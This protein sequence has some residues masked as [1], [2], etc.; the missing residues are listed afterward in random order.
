MDKS[1]PNYHD[2]ITIIIRYAKQ[3]ET[4]YSICDIL[5]EYDDIY[6]EILSVWN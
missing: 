5:K 6:K 1:V 2:E 3:L 4:H